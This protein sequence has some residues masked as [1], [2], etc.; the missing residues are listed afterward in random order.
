[1]KKCV[2]FP[3][4]KRHNTQKDAETAVLFVDNVD[5]RAYFCETYSGWHLAKIKN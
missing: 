5:L 3:D 1:M 2:E 4:K